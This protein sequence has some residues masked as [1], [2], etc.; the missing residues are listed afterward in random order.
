MDLVPKFQTLIYNDCCQEKTFS[1]ASALKSAWL[2]T[3]EGASAEMKDSDVHDKEAQMTV[4]YGPSS[5]LGQ[6]LNKAALG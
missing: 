6:R 4:S 2:M 1:L 3:V 5:H